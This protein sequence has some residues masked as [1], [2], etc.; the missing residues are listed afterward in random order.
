[1]SSV[2][3]R[4]KIV[5]RVMMVIH[6]KSLNE[7]HIWIRIFESAYLNPHIWICIYEFAYDCIKKFW[8]SFNLDA[9]LG[10]VVWHSL[11]QENRQKNKKNFLLLWSG[12]FWSCYFG[13]RDF[14]RLLRLKTVRPVD[15]FY[16]SI[17][18]IYGINIW[19]YH[20]Y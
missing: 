1:M 14:R 6:W 13:E 10:V 18:L 15:T 9:N 16:L 8:H 7:S 12:R 4:V 2:V 17:P 3:R 19:Y 11:K 20:I 5:K